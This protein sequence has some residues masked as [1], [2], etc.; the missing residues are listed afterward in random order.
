MLAINKQVFGPC[1]TR[2]DDGLYEIN[3]LLDM[4]KKYETRLLHTYLLIYLLTC[5]PAYFYQS[6]IGV[7]HTVGMAYH[8]YLSSA[9][10]KNSM[11]CNTLT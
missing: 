2:C 11:A 3:G 7:K 1:V 6:Y 8:C 5:L 10:Y 9:S 4:K